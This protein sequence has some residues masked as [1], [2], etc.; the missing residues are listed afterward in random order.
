MT[1]RGWG[2]DRSLSDFLF[3]KGYCFDFYQAIRL[4]EYISPEKL[5]VGEGSEAE[6]EV[7]R[8]V[9]EVGFD[10]PA[11]AVSEI[12]RA[13]SDEKPNRM[14]VNFMGLAGGGGP[15][16]APYTELILDGL[17]RKDTA[18]KDFLDIFNHRLISLMYRVRKMYRIAFDIGPPDQSHFA[19]YLFSLMGMGT[20]GLRERMDVRDRALLFYTS[21]LA[22]QPRSMCALESILSD[23]FQI[24]VRGKQL[25]GAWYPIAED[26]ITHIGISGQ[27]Q[28]LGQSSVIGTRV[29]DQQGKYELRIGPMSFEE[30]LDFLPDGPSFTP[31]CQLIRFYAGT[32]FG[33][34]FVL[35]LKPDEVPE[36][37]LGGGARLGWTSWLRTGEF[38]EACGR[39]RIREHLIAEVL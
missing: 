28:C 25:C 24:R 3:D 7:V 19:G 30:F 10:F 29:W 36:I 26:Q 35:L 20:E 21:L 17:R 13:E 8:F 22:Q 15:L 34:D 14:T 31:L 39:V 6:K 1:N 23:Y 2:T 27:N 4:L 38:Q 33:F 37:R 11:S 32:E 12:T 5:P 16:P 9:S 18:L